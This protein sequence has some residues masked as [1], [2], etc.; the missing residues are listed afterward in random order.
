MFFR[1]CLLIAII[2]LLILSTAE[3]CIIVCNKQ[4][5]ETKEIVKPIEQIQAHPFPPRKR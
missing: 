4:L 2:T 3:G 5:T 1:I